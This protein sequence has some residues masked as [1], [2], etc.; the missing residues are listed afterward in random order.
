MTGSGSNGR[1]RVIGG[2]SV[3]LARRPEAPSS[4]GGGL[5]EVLRPGLALAQLREHLDEAVELGSARVEVRADAQA[6]ARAVVDED[7]PLLQRLDEGGAVLVRSQRDRQGAA[8]LRRIGGA[9]AGE[10]ARRK[11]RAQLLG[12]RDRVPAHVLDADL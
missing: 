9:R 5:G 3:T 8:A 2:S 10:P 4:I 12:Q 11:I 1:F 6:G 7:A